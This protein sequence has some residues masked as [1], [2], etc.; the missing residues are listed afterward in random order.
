MCGDNMKDGVKLVINIIELLIVI[1]VV[2]I[3]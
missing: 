3:T 1:Y 2:F